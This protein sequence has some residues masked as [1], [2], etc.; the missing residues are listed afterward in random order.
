M[1]G[2]KQRDHAVGLAFRAGEHECGVPFKC[3]LVVDVE[4]R[5]HAAEV[6]MLA[7]EHQRGPHGVVCV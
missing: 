1:A 7:G 2:F 6:A 5:L 4:Q 3:G